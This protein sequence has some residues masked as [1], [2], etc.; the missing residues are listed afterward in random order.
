MRYTQRDAG[1][2]HRYDHESGGIGINSYF[3]K[4]PRDINGKTAR[5]Q[6]VKPMSL[7]DHLSFG[8]RSAELTDLS[9]FLDSRHYLPPITKTEEF[10][11]PIRIG[12]L[13]FCFQ[14]KSL[15]TFLLIIETF[16]CFSE[17][18]RTSTLSIWQVHNSPIIFDHE[19]MSLHLLLPPVVAY[20]K[21][22]NI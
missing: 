10:I 22:I 6:P 11:P 17:H 13:I 20:N 19:I 8:I 18:G 2:G 3:D 21:N 12:F 16:K 7:P 5:Y 1:K 14:S 9:H 15:L 4:Y